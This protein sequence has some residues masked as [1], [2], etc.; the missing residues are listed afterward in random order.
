LTGTSVTSS[1]VYSVLIETSSTSKNY[2]YHLDL[3]GAGTC[4]EWDISGL[5]YLTGT[6]SG[7]TSGTC[8]ITPSPTTLSSSPL[9][10]QQDTRTLS[11]S[12][13]A[14]TVGCTTDCDSSC[15]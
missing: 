13:V 10:V 14:D 2:L 6:V 8:T 9:I 15:N 4:Y 5:T 11:W 12:I 1:E 3:S 7:S